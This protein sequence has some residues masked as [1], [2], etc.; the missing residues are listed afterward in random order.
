MH[1]VVDETT[2][3]LCLRKG[4][5]LFLVATSSSSALLPLWKLPL[6]LKS[7]I[8]CRLLMFAFCLLSKRAAKNPNPRT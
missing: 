6:P 7:N 8:A 5:F 3:G 2:K 1:K 4:L